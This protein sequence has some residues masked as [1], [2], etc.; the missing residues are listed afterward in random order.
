MSSELRDYVLSVD[1]IYILVIE[2]IGQLNGD[3]I[4]VRTS[5]MCLVGFSLSVDSLI[6]LFSS[7]YS[8]SVLMSL[9]TCLYGPGYYWHQFS[10]VC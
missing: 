2:L 7:V 4:G 1:G 10:G 8:L 9:M 5:K 6:I 3:F